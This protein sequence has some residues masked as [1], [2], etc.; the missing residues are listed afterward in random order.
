MSSG[1]SRIYLKILFIVLVLMTVTNLAYASSSYLYD[2]NGRLISEVRDNGEK[3]DYVYDQNGN[4]ILKEYTGRN[5]DYAFTKEQG[6]NDWYYQIWNGTS[7]EDMTWNTSLSRWEGKTAWEVIGKDWIHPG[8]NDI[9]LTWQVPQSGAIH[10]GGKIKKHQINLLGD[11]INLKVLKNN[12]QIWPTTGWKHLAGDDAIGIDLNLDMN[13]VAGDNVSFILNKNGNLNYD[14]TVWKPTIKYVEKA[15]EGFSSEQGKNNWSYQI[16]TADGYKDMAWDTTAS[17]WRGDNRWEIISQEWMHPHINDAALKWKAPQTGIIHISGNIR[18]HPINLEGDGVDFKIMKNDTQI[19]PVSGWTH[20]EGNDGIGKNLNLDVKVNKDEK[21]YFVLN[22][23]GNLVS[24]ATIVNPK[25]TYVEKASAAYGSEQGKHNWYYQTWDGT[26]YKNMVWDSTLFR[27]KGDHAWSLITKDW[28]HPHTNDTVFKWVAPNTGTIR[29]KSNVKKHPINLIGDGVNTKILKNNTQIWPDSGWKRI[30]GNDG[31]GAS[32]IKE[33]EVTQGDSIYFRLNQNGDFSND[34]TIWDPVIAYLSTKA[35]DPP[36]VT[37]TEPAENLYLDFEDGTVQ[38]WIGQGEGVVLSNTQELAYGG[39]SS[40]KVSNRT[41]GWH[42]PM[43]NITNHIVPQQSYQIKAF[44]RLPQGTPAAQVMMTIRRTLPD[45]NSY[46]D[47][48]ST[49]MVTSSGWATFEGI[50]QLNE[51]ATSMYLY[52]E[53]AS[54]TA[55]FLL[56]NVSIEAYSAEPA[57][58]V[59]DFEDGTT[60]GWYAQGEGVLVANTQE[61]ASSGSH[62]LKISNRS[63]EWQ[64]PALDLTSYMKKGQTYTLSGKLRLPQGV[65]ASDILLTMNR[66]DENGLHYYDNVSASHVTVDGWVDFEGVYT[67]TGTVAGLNIYMESPNATASFYLDDFK[68]EKYVEA[69][70]VVS[71]DFEDETLQGW[72]AQGESVVLQNTGETANGGQRSLKVSDRTAEWQGPLLDLTSLLK[73]NTK[74][75]IKAAV[76]LPQGTAA[77]DLLFT[78]HREAQDGTHSYDNVSASSVTAN[79]WTMINGTYEYNG[80]AAKNL[81]LYVESNNATSSFYI[82]D[83]IILLDK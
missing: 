35:E 63:A 38:N 41:L 77:S 59:H 21:I 62:S 3:V 72:V 44:V 49:K 45:G 61:A 19:W 66:T 24:D 82:D 81:S 75:R 56:D 40:L 1:T 78:I 64:G 76:R 67:F 2:S 57:P 5:L 71:H 4:L 34:G 7:F 33:L 46:Y 80:A 15:S 37:P 26:V 9:A 48:I 54:P 47:N 74:Y 23:Y 55:S 30:E 69:A 17:L 20:L 32:V 12:T 58:L 50:Y 53:S 28:I 51:P 36:V 6:L 73:P 18:K 16:A 39:A 8:V 22:K 60:H 79:E 29:I 10:I 31:K 65:T 70:P 13:V 43:L 25:I 42:G 14:G 68:V 52:L 27:W 83:F 11:G